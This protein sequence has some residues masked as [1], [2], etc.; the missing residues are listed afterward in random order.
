MHNRTRRSYLEFCLPRVKLD[1]CKRFIAFA[2]V[3]CWSE[4][5]HDVKCISS[6][7]KFKVL[8]LREF[9]SKYC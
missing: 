5:P 6:L 9:I 2:G 1:V 7:S 4:L 3:H 8:L